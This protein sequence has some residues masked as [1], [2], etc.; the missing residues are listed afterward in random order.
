MKNNNKILVEVVFFLFTIRQTNL[1]ELLLSII[2]NRVKK[3]F[4]KTSDVFFQNLNSVEEVA[5]KL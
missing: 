2:N 1:A 5:L 4:L 3:F